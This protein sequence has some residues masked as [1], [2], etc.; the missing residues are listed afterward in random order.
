MN[1]EILGNL[2]EVKV[3]P[4]AIKTEKDLAKEIAR[5]ANLS[6]L[7]GYKLE[8]EGRLITKEE[9]YQQFSHCASLMKA[10]NNHIFPK[11]HLLKN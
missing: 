1:D 7:L 6:L 8:D 4:I 5:I 11:T 3:Y 10:V 2:N 9:A